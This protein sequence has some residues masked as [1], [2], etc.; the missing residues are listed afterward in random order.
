MNSALSRED[1]LARLQSRF[2]IDLGLSSL[3]NYEQ[4]ELL[5]SP[6]RGGHGRGRG[7]WTIYDSKAVIDAAIAYHFLHGRFGSE[8]ARQR[9][10]GKMPRLP[11]NWVIV[12]RSAFVSIMTQ[13]NWP[14]TLDHWNAIKLLL[15]NVVF[16]KALHK[17]KLKIEAKIMQKMNYVHP[18]PIDDLLNAFL[19]AWIAEYYYLREKIEIS[20]AKG[21][22]E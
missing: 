1:L 18:E 12:L 14:P 8:Q 19:N 11:M 22:N 5:D 20:M 13:A 3:L 17:A 9:F 7:K 4:N 2:G 21:A 16:E 15:P 10:D 6:S